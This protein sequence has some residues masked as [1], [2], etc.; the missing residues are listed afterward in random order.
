[1]DR[2]SSI[3][4][5]TIHLAFVTTQ[6]LSIWQVAMYII[7][8]QKQIEKS[9][10]KIVLETPNRCHLGWK[11]TLRKITN[12]SYQPQHVPH[13]WCDDGTKTSIKSSWWLAWSPVMIY[14]ESDGVYKKVLLGRD[15]RACSWIASWWSDQNFAVLHSKKGK[16][17]YIRKH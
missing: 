17:K 9:F 15:E 7:T 12:K 14:W 1:M 13:A 16:W 11:L 5:T 10:S 2:I 6:A 8:D 4:E 3:A